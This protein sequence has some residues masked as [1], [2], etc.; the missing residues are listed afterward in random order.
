M[1]RQRG[2]ASDRVLDRTATY[3]GVA[4]GAAD[5]SAALDRLRCRATARVRPSVRRHRHEWASRWEDADIAIVGDPQMQLAVRFAIFHLL[6][7]APDDGEAA[8]GARG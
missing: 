1:P 4:R 6:A 2:T 7:S 8:V 3:D 5:E